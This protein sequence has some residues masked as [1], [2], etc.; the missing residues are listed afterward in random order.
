MQDQPRAGALDLAL[1][2][3]QTLGDRE[4]EGELF[5]LFEIQAERLFEVI[6]RSEDPAARAEAAHSLKGGAAGVG[7]V[8]VMRFAGEIELMMRDGDEDPSTAVAELRQ[9]LHDV[10]HAI[11]AWRHAS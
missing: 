6:A 7:A 10:R 9:A 1:L 5:A 4:L 2:A 3:S 11:G 8:S